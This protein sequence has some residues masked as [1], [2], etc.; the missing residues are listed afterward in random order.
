MESVQQVPAEYPRADVLGTAVDCV[1][2]EDAIARIEQMIVD[3]VPSLVF[4]ADA[5]GLAMAQD[6]PA[7]RDIIRQAAL[8]TPDSAGVVWAM[9]RAG[10][11][12]QSRVSGVDLLDRLCE[13]SA[14][15]GYR[16]YFLG[17]APGVAELAAERMR[18]RHPGCNIVGARHGYFPAE[19]DEVVAQEVAKAKPDIL[20][21]AMGMPRQER[22]ILQTQSII[23]APV[24]IGVGGSFDVFS[25]RV[26]RAPKVIQKM[27][28]EWLWRLLL[29]PKKISKA[30]YLPKFVW[31]VWKSK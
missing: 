29:N 9:K 13:R 23:R 28:L 17:A 1:T 20:F 11:T 7:F 18:L 8:I 26:K 4:T 15:H 30:K 14:D 31:R 27:K 12:S 21:V 5:S 16:I 10:H 22:F 19:S 3:R 2:M 6:D 24:A 25:G